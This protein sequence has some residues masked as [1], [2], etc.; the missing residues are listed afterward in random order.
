MKS[1]DNYKLAVLF[2]LVN[3]ILE[4]IASKRFDYFSLV[5]IKYIFRILEVPLY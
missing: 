4:K 3:N 5:L 1:M 2:T